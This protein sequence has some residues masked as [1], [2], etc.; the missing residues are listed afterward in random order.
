MPQYW[1]Q[2]LL[3]ATLGYVELPIG[4]RQVKLG[5]NFARNVFPYRNGQGVEDLGRKVYL[6]TLTVPLFRGMDPEHYPDTYLRLLAIIEDDELR[7]EVEY[8]DP[9]FGPLD[10]KI[11]DYD[12]HTVAERRD[13][14]V[15]TITLEERGFDTSVLDSINLPTLSGPRRAE[16]FALD[17]DRE[18]S[19]LSADLGFSLTDAWRAFQDALDQG[20]LAVDDIA[21]QL[22]EIYL[23]AEKA[24]AFSAVDEIER[25]SLYNSIVDFLGA[26]EDSADVAADKSVG[27]RLVEVVLPDDMDMFQ[28]ASRYLKDASRAEEVAFY[29]PTSPLSYPRGST[30][31][32]PAS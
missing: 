23:V 26:A 31:R 5:R 12:W 19:L 20:A 10:V 27:A 22:D 6:F 2:N 32:V 25:W 1:E 8:V 15:L 18:A 13:G 24:I 11:V 29:N 14:G 30:V 9:E 17:V 28:I 16:Q 7:G 3:S 4:D 21:A